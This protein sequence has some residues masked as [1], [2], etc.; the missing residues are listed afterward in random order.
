MRF[1]RVP[2]LAALS[3]LAVSPVALAQE[4]VIYYWG[5]WRNTVVSSTA[6]SFR[7]WSAD[8]VGAVPASFYTWSEI[9]V[10]SPP[11]D[12]LA[13]GVSTDT[14][15][16][17]TA[18]FDLDTDVTVNGLAAISG[19]PTLRS[20]SS[21]YSGFINLEQRV[22]DTGVNDPFIQVDDT[23]TM[24]MDDMYLGVEADDVDLYKVGE[25]T[26]RLNFTPM[27]MNGG[28]FV[29]A[30]GTVQI[31]DDT[32]LVDN[33]GVQFE[34]GLLRY[35]EAPADD[36]SAAF[37]DSSG[38]I[39]IDNAGN[40][41]RFGNAIASSNTGGFEQ[42]GTGR[43]IFAANNAYSGTTRVLEGTLQIGEDG[44]TG[45]FSG[46]L[47]NN[48]VVE[49]RRSNTQVYNGAISGTGAIHKYNG[50]TLILGGDSTFSGTTTIHGG[51]LQIGNDGLTGSLVGDIVNNG[52][53][54]FKRSETPFVS[55]DLTYNGVISGTGTVHKSGFN[56][57]T[58]G[59]SNSYTGN[60][61]IEVGVLRA[62]HSSALG[63]TAGITVVQGGASLQLSG[64]IAI[65]AEALELNGS[66]Y[67][68]GAIGTLSN[69]SGTNSY[70]GAIDNRG[71][72]IQSLA[73]RLTLTGPI[74]SSG[75]G[76]AGLDVS[77]NGELHIAGDMTL[78]PVRD[79]TR[80]NGS[81]L[82]IL[83][84]SNSYRDTVINSG[85]VQFGNDTTTGNLGTGGVTLANNATLAFRRSDAY[86]VGN[87]ISGDGNLLKQGV[88]RLTLTGSNS[89]SGTTTVNNGILEVQNNAALGTSSA[90]ILV[91][92]GASL[93]LD[94]GV[95][96]SG[97]PLEINDAG[98]S[99]GFV[100]ALSSRNGHN[101]FN[102]DIRNNFSAIQAQ[103]GTLTVN[104]NIT[105]GAGGAS[106]NLRGDGHIVL[107]GS[108]N[109]GA[110]RNLN[111][112][113]GSGT[114][115][116]AGAA[117]YA[118]TSIDSGVLQI[119]NGGTAGNLGTGQVFN[120]GGLAFNRS[121]TL[122]V[123]NT[124]S[125]SGWV[126]QDGPGTTVLTGTSTY[127]GT[128]AVNA[129]T[130][131][132]NGALQGSGAVSVADGARLGGGGTINGE[133]TV[134]GT[135]GAGNSPGLLTIDDF[136]VLA[137]GSALDVEI[138]GVTPGMEYDRVAV[139]GSVSLDGDNDLVLTLMGFTPV[140][141]TMFFLITGAT[142]LSGTFES[143]NGT[144]T[145]LSQGAEFV[146]GGQAFQISYTGNSGSNTFAGGGNDLVLMAVP[147]P[148]AALATLL[149]V[150][151][152]FARRRRA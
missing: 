77:G 150:A 125:G 18:F 79:L 127:S 63:S 13:F 32:A 145:D 19:N 59:G 140:D 90:G 42:S 146:A 50:N 135:L 47:R 119:G 17:Y 26:L 1:L 110:T 53:L 31:D 7:N 76:G 91:Q 44:T 39:R 130:L 57:L 64:G 98:F 69:H 65:G 54:V 46:D 101:T 55:A 45:S 113:L 137:D 34:G 89:F 15:A 4:P 93:L 134:E 128:T 97:K 124:I 60:T 12:F 142:G 33:G 120:N 71:S 43:M 144:V 5:A 100:G 58:F 121:G 143:L 51:T 22:F 73:G 62:A 123:A 141:G 107:N 70:A 129:G 133:V 6:W 99:F 86:E 92:G 66:G 148:S 114:A 149:G 84:G 68:F 9:S 67:S 136:L 139:T 109:L 28:N 49:F 24:Y 78:G 96:I 21:E 118:Q 30:E 103:S 41:L 74:T 83:S 25:G 108:V 11:V 132:V 23:L 72:Q 85:T 126:R 14:P 29:I 115:V 116:I 106:L 104:G 20:D 105:T 138:E 117:T 75:P 36:P 37:R 152:L 80:I 81:G 16:S 94:G 2:S 88:G 112:D 151:A 10:Q 95:T 87:I 102:G 111:K 8:E 131:V 147:E 52:A 122:T 3:F 40:T 82:T 35:L 48:S 61:Q 38:A 56:T 27:F